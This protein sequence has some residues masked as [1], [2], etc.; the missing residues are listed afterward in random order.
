MQTTTP[1]GL[2]PQVPTRWTKWMP[3]ACLVLLFVLVHLMLKSNYRDDIYFSHALDD[4]GLMPWLQNRYQTWSSR[5]LLETTLVLVLR[6]PFIAWITLDIGMI[7]LLFSS[8]RLLLAPEKKLKESMILVLLVCLYPFFHMGSAGWVST[9]VIYLWPLS[10]AAYAFSG[11]VRFMRGEHIRWYRW[12]MYGASAFYGCNNELIAM[13]VLAAGI[14][15]LVLAAH[16]KMPLT[17]PV[18]GMVLSLGCLAFAVT[19]P[20][21]SVRMASET[22]SWMPVFPALSLL[23]KMRI[24]IVS[25]MEHFLSIPNAVLFLFLL[26]IAIIVFRECDSFKKRV[27][28][29]LPLLIQLAYGVYFAVEKLFFTRDFSYSVPEIEPESVSGMLFQGMM[30]AAFAVMLLCIAFSLSWILRDKRKLILYLLALGAALATRLSLSFSPTVLASGTR[31]YMFIY[32]VLLA[33]TFLLWKRG[34][35]KKMEYLILGFAFIGNACNV[36]MIY[37]MQQKN[38]W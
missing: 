7:L 29:A 34:L 27:A 25:T 21:N 17:V 13:M 2:R 3:Y 5:L 24:G 35:P 11:M 16:K 28:G 20:G 30:A 38:L 33:I 31:T 18:F 9:T 26:L 1:A 37:L 4:S 23:D 19:T 32:I 6:L 10:L 36:A 22:A 15:G 12:L 8:L 14:G